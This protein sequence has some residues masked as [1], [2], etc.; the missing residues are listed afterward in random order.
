MKGKK[1]QARQPLESSSLN[2][3]AESSDTSEPRWGCGGGCL[4][5]S[6]PGCPRRGKGQQRT[7]APAPTPAPAGDRRGRP[8]LPGG[9]LEILSPNTERR[10]RST[11]GSLTGKPAM[12]HPLRWLPVR[13]NTLPWESEARAEHASVRWEPEAPGRSRRGAGSPPHVAG[14][15]LA[16]CPGE[17][18]AGCR[19]GYSPRKGAWAACRGAGLC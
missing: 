8:S 18:Q 16:F 17:G 5:T 13:L 19:K 3:T 6:T 10:E 4:P 15:R 11:A 2:H 14:S 9:T 12:A 7:R 1:P